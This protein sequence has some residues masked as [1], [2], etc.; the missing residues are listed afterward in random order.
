[1][2]ARVVFLIGLLTSAL[3]VSVPAVD[4]ARAPSSRPTLVVL[5]VVD[6]MRADYLTRYE[7][8]FK[9]GLKRLLTEGAFFERAAYPYLSTLTCAGHATIA[10]GA[11]PATHGII[12]NEWWSRA[13][14]RRVLCTEDAAV[15]NLSYVGGVETPGHSARRLQIPTLG[16][17]LKSIDQTSQVVTLSMKPRSA[18]M[19]AGKGPAS[20]TWFVDATNGWATSTAYT[21]TPL[22]IVRS[23]LD[24][25]PMDRDRAAVWTQLAPTQF[26]GP[27]DGVGERPK[28]GW[29]ATFP[30]PLVG[31]PGTAE[32]EYYELWRCSPFADVY[33]AD[34]AIAQADALKLGQRGVT[35]LLG[36]GLS[37][38]DCVGHDFGPDSAEV[39]DTLLR[40]DQTLGRLFDAL[41]GQVGRDNYVVGLSADHGVSPIPEQRRSQGGDAGR[42]LAPEVRKVAEAAMLAAHGP[43]PHVAAVVPP[44]ISFTPATRALVEKSPEAAWPAIE[45]VSKLSGTLRVIPSRSLDGRRASTD[46]VERAAALSYFPAESGDLMLILKP[47]WINGDASAASHG[48]LNSY[49]QRV[50]VILMGPRIRSGRYTGDASPADIVPTLAAVL[51]L[52]LSGID[53]KALGVAL[54]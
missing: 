28:A 47:Y 23:F 25:Q 49:D 14:N 24:G 27:D 19:L 40:L 45:A 46:P 8:Q 21:A 7:Q 33:L 9:A 12:A 50:P 2:R 42:V 38:L 53:G 44:Y 1:M 37:S 32:T 22:A 6:Q 51:K 26:S 41:D 13:E 20:V 35:D 31:A 34:L 54:R 11:F 16:E 3:A 52:N 17:R 39:H 29:S 10:T 36:V 4:Q 43:G 15:T 5:L 30:H 18:I 48:T